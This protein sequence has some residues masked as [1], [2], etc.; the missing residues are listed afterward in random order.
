MAKSSTSWSK[1]QSGNPGGRPKLVDALRER[2]LKAVDE[3]ILEAWIDE[4]TERERE[5]MTL[6]GPVVVVE[7]G[8][9]WVKCSE[10]LA[11][12]GMGKPVQ[13]TENKMLDANDEALGVAVTFVKAGG[14]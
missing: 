13:P 4:C 7:R 12:Y 1:G 6:E 3:K 8:K 10:L 14:K 9:N 5:V 11:A 2:A